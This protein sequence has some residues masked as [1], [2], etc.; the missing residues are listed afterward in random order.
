MVYVTS[1]CTQHDTSLVDTLVIR[2]SIPANTYQVSCQRGGH[3]ASGRQVR[4]V[5]QTIVNSSSTSVEQDLLTLRPNRR[6]QRNTFEV[7]F[8]EEG[9]VDREEQAQFIGCLEKVMKH[10]VGISS[11]HHLLGRRPQTTSSVRTYDN[12]FRVRRIVDKTDL[13]VMRPRAAA[14]QPTNARLPEQA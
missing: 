13:L 14:R 3:R 1:G 9:V 6:L 11:R 5:L 8:E 12:R 4:W 7:H 2:C 10:E